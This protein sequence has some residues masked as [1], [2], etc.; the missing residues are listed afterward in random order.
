MVKQ[1]LSVD[2]FK[3]KWDIECDGCLDNVDHVVY[4]DVRSVF[5]FDKREW[6]TDEREIVF[7]CKWE[8]ISWKVNKRMKNFT[9][10]KQLFFN[11]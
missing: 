7:Q 10:I 5:V 3:E 9:N 4:L 2:K 1:S 8:K 6:S 11:F